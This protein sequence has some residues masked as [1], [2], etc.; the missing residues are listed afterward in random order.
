MQEGLLP[1][2]MLHYTSTQMVWKCGEELRFERGVIKSL[3]DEAAE[4]L[5]YS[6]DLAFGSGWLW[7]LDT[8]IK[9]KRFAEYLPSSLD[10]PLLSEPE[11]F[12]LWYDL[13]E[14]YTQ[15]TFTC[16]SDRL[17]AISG[18]AKIFGNMIRSQQY[19]AGLWKPDLIRGLLWQTKGA[20]LIRRQSGD[21]TQAIDDTF[22]S[23]S[24]AS[25]GYKFVMENQKK[26]NHFQALSEVEDVQI[27]LIDQHDP[28]GAVRSGT[29]AIT[30]PLKTLPRLYNKEW[31][32]AEALM[33]EF[34]R[35]VSEIVKE[36]SQGV[37]EDRYSSSSGG[38]FVAL[39]MLGGS[40]SLDLLVLEAIIRGK[41]QTASICYRRVGALTLGTSLR[42]ED[43]ASPDLLAKLSDIEKSLTFQLGPRK[44][45][46][47]Q[48]LKA[49][50]NVIA[51][52]RRESWKLG[53]VIIA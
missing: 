3:Q 35:Y 32:C 37:V 8:F 42:E 19:V 18:V 20:K 36:E 28:F 23:W 43:V 50:S 27:N 10:Y 49:S 46:G 2:R 33:S 11:T 14:K 4:F 53:T 25:V 24:W 9:F 6:E 30:G 47:G 5:T 7:G 21:S 48:S 13:I 39:K 38:H 1:S 51:E 44:L 16:F 22:P 17:L 41:S 31:K 34:E 45:L 12:Y 52:M 40:S 15:R 26:N 29:V